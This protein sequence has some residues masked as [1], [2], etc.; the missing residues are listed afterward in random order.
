[1]VLPALGEPPFR[2]V[3]IEVKLRDPV[4]REHSHIEDTAVRYS[5]ELNVLRQVV[6]ISGR[7]LK[8]EYCAIV[9]GQNTGQQRVEAHVSTQVVH[10]RSLLH[11]PAEGHLL[12]VFIAPKPAAMIAGSR[13]PL[14]AAKRTLYDPDRGRAGHQAQGP[15]EELTENTA[16]FNTGKIHLS[17]VSVGA[18]RP[19]SF[20][21]FYIHT[22]SARCRSQ[23]ADRVRRPVFLGC[24]GGGAQRFE[25]GRHVAPISRP[26]LVRN[27]PHHLRE[28]LAM[29]VAPQQPFDE[30]FG[31]ADR[32]NP[33]GLSFVDDIGSRA[34]SGSQ[35]RKGVGLGLREYQSVSVMNGGQ[36]KKIG[37]RIKSRQT[38]LRLMRHQFCTFWQAGDQALRLRAYR[39]DPAKPKA[40][41]E[42]TGDFGEVVEP[43]LK[44]HVPGGKHGQRRTGENSAAAA[45][46]QFRG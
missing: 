44:T 21:A 10:H 26:E 45:L 7:W 42:S 22:L 14:F 4:A 30:S 24:Y 5:I 34:V 18:S 41:I 36:Q 38:K 29:G 6:Q 31:V 19:R 28:L 2:V 35:Q 15:A 46:D 40:P 39:A 20:S 8:A 11:F 12:F 13:D 17:G 9:A 27:F 16:R 37:F 23:G 3:G 25:I 33:A 43:L 32:Q 1:M